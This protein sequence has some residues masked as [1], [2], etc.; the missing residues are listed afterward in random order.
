[1]LEIDLGTSHGVLPHG[2]GLV[3]QEYDHPS[4]EVNAIILPKGTQTPCRERSP[5]FRATTD[6]AQAIEVKVAFG[7]SSDPAECEVISHQIDVAGRMS[8]D[9]IYQFVLQVDENMRFSIDVLA[10]EA[11]EGALMPSVDRFLADILAQKATVESFIRLTTL[12]EEQP[13]GVLAAFH[14]GYS[15]EE[16]REILSECGRFGMIGLTKWLEHANEFKS[17]AIQRHLC[18]LVKEVA[19]AEE[20]KWQQYRT[21]TTGQLAQAA[22]MIAALNEQ[23]AEQAELERRYAACQ[24]GISEFQQLSAEIKKKQLDLEQLEGAV[25]AQFEPNLRKLSAKY[26]EIERERGQ[27]EETLRPLLA[28]ELDKAKDE[29]KRKLTNDLAQLSKELEDVEAYAERLDNPPAKFRSGQAP[30][31][32]QDIVAEQEALRELLIDG[33]LRQK[34]EKIYKMWYELK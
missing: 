30:E 10:E 1:M 3:A 21:T 24:E 14:N 31:R 23:K 27:L 26:K 12:M 8:D 33:K 15:E 11:S 22:L 9:S 20:K 2:I 13:A 17:P 29:I 6:Q 5:R 7:N 19:C 4:R 28:E 32:Y 25:P 34:V 16:C 18:D